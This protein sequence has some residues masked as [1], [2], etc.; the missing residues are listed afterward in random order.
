MPSSSGRRPALTLSPSPRIG[1]VPLWLT[2]PPPLSRQ[3]ESAR[4][5][6][7]SVQNCSL[8]GLQPAAE[9]IAR[10]GTRFAS[11]V[12][13]PFSVG[14]GRLGLLSPRIECFGGGTPFLG[15]SGVSRQRMEDSLDQS[16][17]SFEGQKDRSPG[18]RD[19]ACNRDNVLTSRRMHAPTRIESAPVRHRC[20]G[21][22]SHKFS[23]SHAVQCAPSPLSRS[24]S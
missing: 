19:S 13:V 16:A 3:R 11:G 23:A 5:V 15:V 24:R 12:F 18:A 14:F 9:A 10:S 2:E 8:S 21:T 20:C 6:R 4:R 17:R 1:G 22:A 7:L